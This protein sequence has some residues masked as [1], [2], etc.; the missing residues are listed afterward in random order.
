ME[1]ILKNTTITVPLKY[2][3]N[4][5]RSFEMPPV[6]C[7]VELKLRWTKHRVLTVCGVENNDADYNNTIFTIKDTK[8]YV[9]V[10]TLSAKNHQKLSRLL[11][12]WF[13]RSVYWNEYKRE[14][15]NKNTTNEYKYFFESNFVGVNTLFVLVSSN[16]AVY[17]HLFEIEYIPQA[18]LSK[19][20]NKSITHNIFR[21]QSDDSIMCGFYV[22]SW[23]I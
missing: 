16:A 12:K 17:F 13:E 22:L 11:S 3:G 4:F 15:E 23:N 6:N 2:L 7:K 8:P 10:V 20:K 19:I 9:P 14:R 5:W 21:V 1:I 18:V